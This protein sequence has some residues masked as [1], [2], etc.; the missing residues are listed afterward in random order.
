MVLYCNKNGILA[1][2]SDLNLG[3]VIRAVYIAFKCK[4]D[5]IEFRVKIF[6]LR[7]FKN[8]VS[9]TIFLKKN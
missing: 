8:E 1:K 2:K 6:S 5:S 9:A 3:K 7:G 4:K